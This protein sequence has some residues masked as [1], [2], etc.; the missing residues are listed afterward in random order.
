MVYVSP[1]THYFDGWDICCRL[2]RCGHSIST[3][4]CLISHWA[5]EGL[6]P[7]LSCPSAGCCVCAGLAK[8][9]LIKLLNVCGLIY[10]KTHGDRWTAASSSD[11]KLKKR[12][13]KK[14]SVLNQSFLRCSFCLS[15]CHFLPHTHTCICKHGSCFHG[16]RHVHKAVMCL[17]LFL[18][19]Y[20]IMSFFPRFCGTAHTHTLSFTPSFI[21]SLILFQ[22]HSPSV[23]L[24]SRSVD[25]ETI[26]RSLSHTAL[27]AVMLNAP[28]Q[29]WVN[30]VY[31]RYM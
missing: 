10:I 25:S 3:S 27:F 23:F 7:L 8:Y 18:L 26:S 15:T 28:N 13:R 17:V 22:C 14:L 16:N 5:F 1:Y 9:R 4:Y 24:S 21:V 6:L 20:L 29:R 30:P 11:E 12:K 31:S 19:C 2:Q